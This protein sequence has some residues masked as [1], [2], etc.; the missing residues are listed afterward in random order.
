[1]MAWIRSTSGRMALRACSMRL[2][3]GGQLLAGV[4][5]GLLHALRRSAAR[6]IMA[7]H[8]GF[9]LEL[10]GDVRA[11]GRAELVELLE[12]EVLQFAAAS[13]ALL[14][15][16]SDDLMGLAEGNTCLNQ[17]R[18]CGEGI[19][20]TFLASRLHAIVVESDLAH[21]AAGDLQAT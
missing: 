2:L 1:M 7:A 10:L 4:A 15:R 16:V 19:H 21:E 5:D 9:K 13:N 17:V 14:H 18:G 3:Q 12:R 6:N 8:H 20:K 11:Q